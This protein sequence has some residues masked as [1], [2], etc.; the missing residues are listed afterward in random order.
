MST[1]DAQ[2]RAAPAKRQ[3]PI[4]SAASGC[5]SDDPHDC[6]RQTLTLP[7]RRAV[8]A[9][10]LLLLCLPTM[11]WRATQPL[12][13]YC[14]VTCRGSRYVNAF[15]AAILGLVLP[16]VCWG[17]EATPGHPHLRAHFVFVAPETFTVRASATGG[18][19]QDVIQLAS[20]ALANGLHELCSAPVQSAVPTPPAGQ[21]T[22][23]TLAVTL[24]LLAVFGA[25]F[26][27][28]RSHGG[29]FPERLS[30][31]VFFWLPLDVATPPP[32]SI[33]LH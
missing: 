25:F 12:W 26:T 22:P 9:I 19:A 18:N 20:N 6:S 32:R 7:V 13:L 28:H 10:K 5:T 14:R 30:A 16:F 21:S 29:G 4:A 15:L 24:L 11:Q 31:M 33:P 27:L 23:Q 2:L 8:C 1:R 17:A 3:R